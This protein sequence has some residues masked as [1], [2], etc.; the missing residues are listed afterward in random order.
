MTNIIIDCESS[1]PCPMFGDLIEFAAVSENGQTF[2]SDKFPPLFD[3][4]DPGA[5]KVLG[6]TREQHL[7]YTA[8]LKVWFEVFNVWV[9]GIPGF[10][11]RATMWSDNIAYDWQWINWGFA[12][13][14]VPN[15]FG[16]SGRRIGDLFAGARH[17]ISDTRSWK[18]FRITKHTH[19]PL[20]DALGNMEAFKE[21]RKRYR[22]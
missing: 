5:Y 3:V 8:D 2:K 21:I 6:I 4:F 18:K 20:D 16:F 13:A 7:K 19:C 14:G 22:L 12:Y 15:P 17:N 11:G 10:Q 1:G 9:K